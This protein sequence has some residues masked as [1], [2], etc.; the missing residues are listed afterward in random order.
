M[1]LVLKLMVAFEPLSGAGHANGKARPQGSTRL[2]VDHLQT[3]WLSEVHGLC[4][5]W[6]ELMGTV[7]HTFL[8]FVT[9]CLRFL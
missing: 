3:F 4:I 2:Y 7:A 1:C 9:D 8:H 5:P 6:G